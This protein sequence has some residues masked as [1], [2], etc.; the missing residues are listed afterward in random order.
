MKKWIAMLFS[1][2]I[3]V[4]VPAMTKTTC[5]AA[6]AEVGVTTLSDA[7]WFD[8]AWA[9]KRLTITCISHFP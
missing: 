7:A 6:P 3:L 4:V 2:M 5:L 9:E 8:Q 1:M